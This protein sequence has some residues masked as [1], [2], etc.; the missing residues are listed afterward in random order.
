MQFAL[1]STFEMQDCLKT[2]LRFI[3]KKA[4]I[5]NYIIAG[6]NILLNI[7]KSRTK[8]SNYMLIKRKTQTS[9]ILI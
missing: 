3:A 2:R 1:C 4:I 7:L 9:L 5:T 8:K 6:T